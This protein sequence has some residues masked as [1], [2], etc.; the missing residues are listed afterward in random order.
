MRR[1]PE[2]S[3][4]LIYLEFAGLQELGL[5]WRDPD[6]RKLHALFQHG[7]LVRVAAAAE[8][9]LPAFADTLRIL[10]GA[11]VFEDASGCCTVR[12]KLRAI[13]LCGD[14]ETNRIF[15][16]CDG[17]IPN[18]TIKTKTGYV[19][20]MPSAISCTDGDV[21]YSSTYSLMNFSMASMFSAFLVR[22]SGCASFRCIRNICFIYALI[23]I[24]VHA[25]V[26]RFSSE[27]P[28]TAAGVT[29]P[30]HLP[31][32]IK[33]A[34]LPCSIVRCGFCKV[35]LRSLPSWLFPSSQ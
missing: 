32:I 31:V 28:C 23:I 19:Q 21:P 1:D 4:D 26:N 20:H 27:N 34:P 14:G 7:D 24:S 11:G 8:G 22:M 12:E 9:G 35:Y 25:T 5:L 15:C 16:H 2:N 13:F 29:I 17:T 6:G 30:R 33:E 10:N 18:Q 3:S